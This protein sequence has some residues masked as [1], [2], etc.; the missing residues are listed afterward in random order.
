[1]VQRERRRL[2]RI[3]P[4]VFG[5]MAALTL[6]GCAALGAQEHPGGA[7]LGLHWEEDGTL[8]A[9]GSGFA[10]GEGI[11]L[12]LTVQSQQTSVTNAP[13]VMAMSSQSA[14]QSS[15]VTLQADDQGAFR[16]ASRI[17]APAGA[18]VVVTATGAGASAE[19]RTTR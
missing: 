7:A 11:I 18:E 14:R 2:R 6:L 5:L 10:P 16:Y 13:G 17:T 9:E 8:I 12:T 4:G 1:M 19:A 3:V 15:T